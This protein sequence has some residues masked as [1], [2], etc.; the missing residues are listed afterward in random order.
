[1]HHKVINCRDGPLTTTNT[2][3]RKVCEA[4]KSRA[5]ESQ[6]SARADSWPT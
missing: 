3:P 5:A 4:M 2:E 6:D 1:M